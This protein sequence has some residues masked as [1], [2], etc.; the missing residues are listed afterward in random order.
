VHLVAYAAPAPPK[1]LR[2]SLGQPW[3]NASRVRWLT[4]ESPEQTLAI[5]AAS[6]E[7]PPFPVYAVVVIG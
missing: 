3:K 4:A 2:L 5:A 7:I 1:G 6:V